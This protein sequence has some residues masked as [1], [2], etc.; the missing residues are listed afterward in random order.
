MSLEEIFINVVD[1]T[2]P[3]PRYQR[4][5]RAKTDK[6]DDAADEIAKKLIEN[7]T[8]TGKSEKE[9]FSALFGSDEEK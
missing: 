2:A 4:K 9:K 7:A 5:T 6:R 1:R 8:A 3:K